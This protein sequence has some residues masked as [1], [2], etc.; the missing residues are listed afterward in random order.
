MFTYGFVPGSGGGAENLDELNDV[1]VPTPADGDVL[2]YDDAT[3]LWVN[4]PSAGGGGGAENL[5]ELNDVAVPTPADGDVLTYDDATGLWVNAPSA[6]GGGG[7]EKLDDLSD[8]TVT[9]DE[10]WPGP[11]V[12]TGGIG[13]PG[14]GTGNV[15]EF[16]IDNT[17]PGAGVLYGPKQEDNTWPLIGNQN[18]AWTSSINTPVDTISGLGNGHY[19][20]QFSFTPPSTVTLLGV[21]G[22]Y[23]STGLGDRTYV[24]YNQATRQW[25]ESANE[26]LLANEG[27]LHA[28]IVSNISGN[29]TINPN[30][31]SFHLHTFTGNVNYSAFPVPAPR[32]PAGIA[33][34]SHLVIAIRQ[35][36]SGGY[37]ATWPASFVWP[38]GVAPTLSTCVNDVDFFHAVSYDRGTTW[39]ATQIAS[40]TGPSRVEKVADKTADYT[41]TRADAGNIV[42]LSGSTNRQFTIPTNAN[43]PLPV[44]TRITIATVGTAHISLAGGSGVTVSGTTNLNTLGQVATV[45]KIGTDTWI[46][47]A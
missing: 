36:G 6:G 11:F 43:V 14:S 37:T 9:A 7:A 22:P 34:A 47:H 4:A 41:F 26:F 13:A 30:I 24:R 32:F 40:G 35:G 31:A 39:Y 17:T 45:I 12:V 20:V 42:T 18:V 33:R 3:G 29:F 25:K 8:V 46:S 2:T 1:A 16:Y 10:Q 44:G 21:Y 38:G 28:A 15:G 23:T 27:G 5:D 19:H